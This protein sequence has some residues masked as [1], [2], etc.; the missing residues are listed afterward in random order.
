MNL[1]SYWHATSPRHQGQVLPVEGKYDVA[2][3]GG[4]FTGLS[5]ALALA[6]K[7]A[8]VILLEAGRIIGEA[9]GRNG[10]H[11]NNGVAQDFGSLAARLGL[12]QARSLY[13]AYDDAVASV[14]DIV[15]CEAIDCDFR[16]SGKI[17]LAAKPEHFEKLAQSHALLAKE[18]D[19]E[20]DL[21]SPEDIRQEIGSD[22]VFGG[23]VYRKSAQMHMG[24]FGM[25]LA[26]AA[27]RHGAIIHENAAV[28]NIERLGDGRHS[29]TTSRGTVE[30]RQVLIATGASQHGPFGYF[31]RRIVP[32]GSFIIA[33]E[34]LSHNLA[35]AIMPTRRTATTTKNIG[36]YFRLT[37]DNRL[38]FGGRARFALSN[39]ESDLKSG[40]ILIAG[41]RRFF[42]LLCD[43]RVDYCWGGVVDMTA[44]R[45]PRAGEHDGMFYAMGY[46]GHG[47]QMSVHMGKVM[48][49]VM[50][51][52]PELNPFRRLAWPAIT[53][54]FGKPWFLPFVGAYYRFQD[55]RH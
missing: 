39:P 24:R 34:P 18:V 36:H 27:N 22:Q 2:V 7:G 45:L 26:D 48:A 35:N 1:E 53:G 33:T 31:R 54:H 16:Q 28:T 37:P 38:I 8:K 20:T 25:G 17:K 43:V 42:P 52:K 3:I 23:L 15:L 19:P 44:D 32:V 21:V 41:M 12:D 50:D 29:V 10:G 40:Q 13:M 6:R 46:S 51:G 49:E 5:A 30:S 55:W 9:S 47:T 4:G 14:K 11:C